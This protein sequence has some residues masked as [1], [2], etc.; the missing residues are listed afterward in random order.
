MEKVKVIK[1]KKFDV[2][3]FNYT[4]KVQ[5]NNNIRFLNNFYYLLATK[6]KTFLYSRIL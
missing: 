4:K 1:L 3:N 2:N 6:A 5:I